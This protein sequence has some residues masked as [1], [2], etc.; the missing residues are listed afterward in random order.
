MVARRRSWQ[1]SAMSAKPSIASLSCVVFV[2]SVSS[3]V[4]GCVGSGTAALDAGVGL[5]AGVAIDDASARDAVTADAGAADVGLDDSGATQA[6]AD[7]GR[8]EDAGAAAD[9][10]ASAD[11]GVDAGAACPPPPRCDPTPPAVGPT[12]PF[13]RTISRVTTLGNPR[14]RGRDLYL[15]PGQPAWAMAKIAYGVNDDDLQGEDVEVFLRT[16]CTGPWSLVARVTTTNDGDHPTVLGV[17]DTGGRVYLA[18]PTLPVGRHLL[19]FSVVG[20]RSSTEAA[21]EVLPDGAR[22]VVTDIDGTLTSSEWAAVTDVIGLAPPEAHPGAAELMTAFVARG[23]HVLYLTA[24]PEWMGAV[25]RAW[26]PLRG[27]PPGVLHTTLRFTG[28]VGSSAANYKRDELSA[29]AAELARTPAYAFGNKASDAEAYANAGIAPANSFYFD[30][31]AAEARGGVVHA[32]Y[33]ALAPV[34]AGAPPG[35]R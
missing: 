26:L 27:F 1:T 3:G 31:D 32:D 34:A 15:R 18:L 23:Y 17:E 7:A 35:C 5:D 6:D 10:S 4:F 20:D 22:V 25:T 33:R 24:R 8:A 12:E 13:R 11:L 16:G 21:I 9:A 14:H 28:A 30:L 2:W 29:F 19:F